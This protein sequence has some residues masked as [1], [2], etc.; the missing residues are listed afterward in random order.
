MANA[1]NP[2]GYDAKAKTMERHR[3]IYA[4]GRARHL[5]A[6]IFRH[7]VLVDNEGNEVDPLLQFFYP[8]FSYQ[9]KAVM[10]YRKIALEN[11]IRPRYEYDHQHDDADKETE[12]VKNKGKGKSSSD[13]KAKVKKRASTRKRLLEKKKQEEVEKDYQ[14][15]KN[16]IESALKSSPDLWDIYNKDKSEPSTLAYSGPRFDVRRVTKQAPLQGMLLYFSSYSTHDLISF[17]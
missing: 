11:D 15:T 7:F 2:W 16:L 6:W 17:I 13:S 12:Q 1:M 14:A 4:R 10:K 9:A 3:M 8:Y 5:R